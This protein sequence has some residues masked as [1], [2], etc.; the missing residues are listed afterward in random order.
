MHEKGIL[1]LFAP[2]L[3]AYLAISKII[4]WANTITALNQAD[5]GS[6]GQEVL[7]RVL[8]HD[9]PIIIIVT[10]FYFLDKVARLKKSKHNNA[11]KHI[12]LYAIGYV[13]FIGI[14]F[15]YNLIADIIILGQD[16]SLARYVSSF[17][18]V[19]LANTVGFFIATVVLEIKNF[20]KKKGKE[21]SEDAPDRST[22][23]KL[24][25]L[26]DLLDDGIL[27]QEEFDRK[28]E[29]LAAQTLIEIS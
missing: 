23:D 7:T 5:I 24:A 6:M 10:A 9:L 18:N 19:L 14:I 1:S 3:I 2:I 17:L 28:K 8:N 11:L 20:F 16:F 22:E 12:V 29:K 26:K 27:T 25:M 15:T 13:I 4:Y 21:L